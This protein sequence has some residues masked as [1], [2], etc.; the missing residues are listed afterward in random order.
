MDDVAVLV[1]VW[2]RTQ[3]LARVHD[4]ALSTCSTASVVFVASTD[5][6]PMLDAL[7]DLGYDY[8]TLD[9]PGGCPG[10]YARKINVGYRLTS[11]PHLFTGADDLV[12]REG[13]YEAASAHLHGPIGV[14]GTN[15]L[16]NPR[17]I[18]GIHSTH[19]LVARWYADAGACVDAD[20]V[21]YAECYHHEY[22]DDEMINTAK[23]RGAYA[24]AH[25]SIVEHVHMLRDDALDDEVYQHGR[26]WS[27]LS[28]RTYMRRRRLWMEYGTRG[29]AP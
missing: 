28:R 1:P 6:E 25:D 13:W 26:R 7:R 15:D 3:H 10:D 24:H 20:H 14:V 18:E 16:C 5:D 4:S 12:F 23:M 9:L 29:V 17:V 21:I 11:A 8:R 2:K 19:S 22:C 27:R